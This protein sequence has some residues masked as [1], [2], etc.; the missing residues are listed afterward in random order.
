[1]L[2]G[3]QQNAHERGVGDAEEVARLEVRHPNEEDYLSRPE[4]TK[5]SS[6]EGKSDWG[7]MST[8]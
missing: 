7:N 5:R 4:A 3:V 8:R 6:S 2:Q 1:M